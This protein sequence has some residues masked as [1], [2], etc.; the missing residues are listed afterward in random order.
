MLLIFIE[1]K[2]FL[3]SILINIQQ[4]HIHVGIVKQQKCKTY[5][6]YFI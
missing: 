2:A 1:K 3:N 4:K 6:D 5:F